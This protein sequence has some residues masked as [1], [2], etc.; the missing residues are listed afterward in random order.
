MLLSQGGTH[1]TPYCICFFYFHLWIPLFLLQ[2][3]AE[4]MWPISLN[5]TWQCTSGNPA[6][7]PVNDYRKE[8]INTR[9]HCLLQRLMGTRNV[10][11]YSFPFE[12]KRSLNSNSGKM[13]LWD[14][15]PP[16]SL[17]AFRIKPLFLCPSNSFLDLSACHAGSSKNLDPVTLCLSRRLSEHASI[18]PSIFYF[19]PE[20]RAVL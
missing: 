10:W 7:P 9:P 2:L 3:V 8:E 1:L 17:P 14:G 4:V 13:V 11:L 15:S 12:Y 16:L 6:S 5:Y 19:P 20:K 18:H